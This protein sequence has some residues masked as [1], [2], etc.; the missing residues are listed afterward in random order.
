MIVGQ[1]LE[2]DSNVTIAPDQ[3]PE[4]R[5]SESIWTDQGMAFD[6]SDEQSINAEMSIDRSFECASNATIDRIRHPEKQRAQRSVMDEGM[7]SPVGV[8]ALMESEGLQ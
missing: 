3:Y 4:K 6:E 8:S 2:G 1:S 5:Y 7:Q